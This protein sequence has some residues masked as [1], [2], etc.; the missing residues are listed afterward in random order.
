MA[1]LNE[2]ANELCNTMAANARGLGISVSTLECGTRII[3]CGVNAAG[4]IGAGLQL[5][6]VCL[7][8]L[9]LVDVRENTDADM[10]AERSLRVATRSPVAA[11]MASQYAGWELKG[12][13]FFAMGSGPM[14]AAA[15][16]E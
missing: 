7:S 9:G 14:R 3:D 5:A 15:C 1:S 2:R 10:P 8:G 16:R 6:R 11:C 13:K 4:G 12:E